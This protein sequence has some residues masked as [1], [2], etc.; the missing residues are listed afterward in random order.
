MD[1]GPL[2]SALPVAV[3]DFPVADVAVDGDAGTD[4]GVCADGDVGQDCGV[5]FDDAGFFERRAGVD[6]GVGVQEDGGANSRLERV[7]V[8]VGCIGGEGRGVRRGTADDASLGYDG[9]RVDDQRAV[10]GDEAGA[11]VDEDGGAEGDR[12]GA[13]DV[14]GGVEVGGWVDVGWWFGEG[15]RGGGGGGGGGGGLGKVRRTGTGG[16]FS[17]CGASGC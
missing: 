12:V 15:R 6:S 14:G 17:S 1:R 9:A 16:C 7:G 5:G 11:G 8:R 4:L 13:E 3:H 10:G 2:A